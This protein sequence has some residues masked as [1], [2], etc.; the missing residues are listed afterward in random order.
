MVG[1]NGDECGQA[2]QLDFASDWW[3]DLPGFDYRPALRGLSLAL[4]AGRF[5]SRKSRWWHRVSA[6]TGLAGSIT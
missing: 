5:H 3:R 6:S 4:F 1:A 2:L